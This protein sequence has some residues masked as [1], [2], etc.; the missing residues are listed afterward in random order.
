M[1]QENVELGPSGRKQ[2]AR[3]TWGRALRDSTWSHNAD[4]SRGGPGAGADITTGAF[5]KGS[6]SSSPIRDRDLKYE[7]SASLPSPLLRLGKRRES[8]VPCKDTLPHTMLYEHGNVWLPAFR[9]GSRG[10]QSRRAAGVGDVGGERGVR[11]TDAKA[12]HAGDVEGARFVPSSTQ[13]SSST[14]RCG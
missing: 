8:R 11:A 4:D 5:W 13:R 7:T 3:E 14:L 1:S 6:S 2:G 12:F 9:S 10:P